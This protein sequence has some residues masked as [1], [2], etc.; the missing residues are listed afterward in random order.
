MSEGSVRMITWREVKRREGFLSVTVWIPGTVKQ[1]MTTLALQR[2]QDLGELI[3]EAFKAWSPAKSV[4]TVRTLTLEQ[5]TAMMDQKIAEALAAQSTTA[6]PQP[7]LPTVVEETSQEA[8]NALLVTPPLGMKQC[9]KGH[10]PYQRRPG[11][12]AGCPTCAMDR[13]HRYRARKAAKKQGAVADNDA[14]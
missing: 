4:A 12:K 7:A 6:M 11:R 3:V 13:T 9:A 1:A 2:H 10:A 5:A 14:G 8:H